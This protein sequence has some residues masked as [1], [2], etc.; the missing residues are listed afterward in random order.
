M[1]TMDGFAFVRALRQEKRFD[2]VPVV[3]CTAAFR[4]REMRA[5]AHDVGVEHVLFKPVEPQA[6]IDVVRAAQSGLQGT[7][8]GS[9][10]VPVQ[11]RTQLM[12][13]ELVRNLSDLEAANL[14][15]GA[16]TRL[17]LQLASER[18]PDLLLQHVCRGARDLFGARYAILAVRDRS[19][20]RFSIV[21]WGVDDITAERVR[22]LRVDE[23]I[24][25]RVMRERRTHRVERSDVSGSPALALLR[26]WTFGMVAPIASLDRVYGWVLLLDSVDGSRF[27]DDDE[28]LLGILTS[29]AGRI[30]ENGSLN[31]QLTSQL[32]E[33]RRE[34]VERV[35]IEREVRN[36]NRIYALRSGINAAIIRVRSRE[37]LYQEICQVAVEKGAFVKAWVVAFTPFGSELVASTG[38]SV[39]YESELRTVARGLLERKDSLIE[40]AVRGRITVANDLTSNLGGPVEEDRES[41]LRTEAYASG[42]RSRAWL[43]ILADGLVTAVVALHASEADFF[44]VDEQ[45][46]LTELAG[47]IAFALEQMDK[48]QKLDYLAYYDA[49]TGIANAS[50]FAERLTQSVTLAT[51]DHGSIAVV[52]ADVNRFTSIND[53][54]GRNV[55]DEMLVAIAKRLG[56]AVRDLGDV[57]RLSGDTFAFALAGFT[58]EGAL[59]RTIEERI[60]AA[61]LRPFDIHGHEL[62]CAW[63]MGIALFPSDGT[64]A[65]SLL[66]HAETALIRAKRGPDQYLF[67]D[68]GMSARVAERVIFENDLRTGLQRN[69][70]FLFYQ[71]KVHLASSKVTS[72]EALLRWRRGG[73]TLVLPD[74][75]IPIL[76]ETGMIVD[77]GAWVI[78]QA[79][80]DHDRWLAA[81]ID[82]PRVSVNVS[83]VQLRR[84]DFVEMIERHG[85]KAFAAIDIEITES[86]LMADISSNIE[87]LA[88]LAERGMDIA[89]DDFGTGYSSFAY[90]TR[91]PARTLKIDKSFIRGLDSSK[92]QQVLVATIISMA[93]SLNM[94]VV[95]EGVETP[96]EEAELRSLACDEAQGY[97]YGKPMPFDAFSEFLEA[98]R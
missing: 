74:N 68:E 59:A 40:Q 32:A 72:A 43:P 96:E 61:F 24:F 89:I 1:P 2:A 81:G 71:P 44:T 57:G 23:G 64:D 91:L 28:Q 62:R 42:S 51:R 92:S 7:K 86:I 31:A 66:H 17:G 4:E 26:D 30:Y 58:D 15:L 29:Q 56:H 16:M 82:A 47:D 93:H 38:C 76:E 75:F 5:L 27:G 52:V 34:V 70:F 60:I 36:L 79:I 20:A 22:S 9:G 11:R 87:K 33:L 94:K 21:T 80:R 45:A 10:T 13:D 85:Q 83:S 55:G 73:T 12:T 37:E 48:S 77:V 69:E 14:R 50:L 49:L 3:F 39:A 98:R 6:I 41:W 19:D 95:A 65:R 88:V 54:F 97:L 63:K 78:E 90:V 35:A 25:G 53:A 46:P 8:T 67:Y 18:D 84:P